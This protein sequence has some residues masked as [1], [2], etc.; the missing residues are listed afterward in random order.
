[1]V[2]YRVSCESDYEVVRDRDDNDEWDNGEDGYFNHQ[3]SVYKEGDINFREANDFSFESDLPNPKILVVIYGDGCTFG[4]TDGYVMYYGPFTESEAIE[5][6]ALINK[7][8]TE[9]LRK[10]Y[11]EITG[12][13]YM[14]TPW[15]GYFANLQEVRIL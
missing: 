14:S 1:M 7:D 15:T 9:Q 2:N 11:A 8:L 4:H 3:F 13:E 5:L 12:N 10:R 6:A